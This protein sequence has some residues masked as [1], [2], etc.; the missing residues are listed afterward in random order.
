MAQSPEISTSRFSNWSQHLDLS[1]FRVLARQPA[2]RQN[3]IE[4]GNVELDKVSWENARENPAN[5]PKARK[6]IHTVV[7]SM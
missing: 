5:W 7:P 2:A 1:L 6:A 4:G 3:E